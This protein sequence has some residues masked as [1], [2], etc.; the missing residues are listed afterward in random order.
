MRAPSSG[1]RHN[2]V[3]QNVRHDR[4]GAMEPS[5]S[6]AGTYPRGDDYP[7]G[8]T[9]ARSSRPMTSRALEAA[10]REH[11]EAHDQLLQFSKRRTDLAERNPNL[12]KSVASDMQSMEWKLRREYERAVGH[13]VPL[14]HQAAYGDGLELPLP[15][16]LGGPDLSLA[17]L[18][19]DDVD[20]RQRPVGLQ[21][22]Q[23]DRAFWATRPAAPSRPITPARE[24]A[25]RFSSVA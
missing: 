18:V 11:D 20:W 24:I 14:E 22:F 7:R 21:E 1:D 9:S 23:D 12:W 16:G 6:F 10:K 19:G 4:P 15:E 2:V 8:D 25:T 5:A 13:V 17:E 3:M